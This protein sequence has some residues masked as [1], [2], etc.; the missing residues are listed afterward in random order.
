MAIQG[1]DP[2]N[3]RLGT[4][5]TDPSA[6]DESGSRRR[7]VMALVGALALH[8]FTLTLVATAVAMLLLWLRRE[9]W[10]Q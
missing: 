6:Q 8:P 4:P 5:G 9:W 2:R 10:P 1:R 3:R 7:T